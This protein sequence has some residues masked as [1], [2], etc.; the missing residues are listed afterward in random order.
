MT[1][2]PAPHASP[3]TGPDPGGGSFRPVP[4]CSALRPAGSCPWRCGDGATHRERCRQCCARPAACPS[5]SG[6]IRP[7]FAAFRRPVPEQPAGLRDRCRSYGAAFVQIRSAVRRGLTPG[8]RDR[9]FRC[10]SAGCAWPAASAQPGAGVLPPA[11]LPISPDHFV[12]GVR[13]RNY[14]CHG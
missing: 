11:G 3:R 10:R 4:F 14:S 7:A 12:A 6:C 5:A 1:L 13:K 9:S 2:S 8:L